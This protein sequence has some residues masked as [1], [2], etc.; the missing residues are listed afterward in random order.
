[1]KKKAYTTPSVSVARIVLDSGIAETISP[2]SASL[3]TANQASWSADDIIG[4][5][6]S[7]EDGGFY[8]YWY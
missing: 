4:D 3:P 2:M 8:I 6:T 5:N 1:M 7:T